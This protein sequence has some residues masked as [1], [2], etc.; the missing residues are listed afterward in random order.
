MKSTYEG[1]ESG[2]GTVHNWTSQHRDVGNG[3]I[4]IIE[5]VPN[6]LVLTDLTFGEISSHGGWT[7]RDTTDGAYVTTYMELEMGFL[8]RIFPSL[9]MDN[10][11]GADFEKSLAGLKKHAE[12]L[13]LAKAETPGIA[14]ESITYKEQLYASVRIKT[15]LQTIAN[16]MSASYQKIGVFMKKNDIPI[17]DHLFAFYHSIAPDNINIEPAVPIL[18]AVKPE[19]DILVNTMKPGTAAVA[20][21]YGSYL[22]KGEAYA[23]LENWLKENNK[24]MTGSPW[25]VYITD[26]MMEKDTSK[27]QT[28]VY[29]PIE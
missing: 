20:H 11:L 21:Y 23:A 18:K 2:V 16:D 26:P 13:K 19:G 24:K 10:F 17:A 25:E 12:T 7:I 4:K 6:S 8:E 22:R 9:M 29:Y 1:P 27:W 3:T 14:I 28:D 15:S 5:S